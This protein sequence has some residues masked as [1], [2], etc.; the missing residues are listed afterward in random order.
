MKRSLV[1]VVSPSPPQLEEEGESI[2]AELAARNEALQTAQA[3]QTEQ[4][5]R[6]SEQLLRVEERHGT[7][8][9]AIQHLEAQLKAVRGEGGGG[10][11]V[12][13]DVWGGREGGREGVLSSAWRPS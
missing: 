3:H 1:D 7:A 5:R 12:R 8:E 13:R 11:G 10:E 6:H 2:R 9:S 4:Q